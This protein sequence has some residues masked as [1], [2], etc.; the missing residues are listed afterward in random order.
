MQLFLQKNS[1][2]ATYD[3]RFFFLVLFPQ[4]TRLIKYLFCLQLCLFQLHEF[5]DSTGIQHLL[6]NSEQQ[7]H[8][9]L[10]FRGILGNSWWK[11]RWRK[12][13]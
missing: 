2:R 1:S 4:Y 10:P 13:I 3:K 11:L 9:S 12:L 7:H 5:W 8:L 6:F